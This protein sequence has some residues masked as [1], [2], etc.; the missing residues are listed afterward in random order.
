MAASL[1]GTVVEASELG[2]LS[3]VAPAASATMSTWNRLWLG[4]GPGGFGPAS[5]VR[6]SQSVAALSA[7]A[8]GVDDGADMAQKTQINV[9]AVWGGKHVVAHKLSGGSVEARESPRDKRS[10]VFL[11]TG[12]NTLLCPLRDGRRPV[13]AR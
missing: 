2:D 10:T 8:E 3:S 13:V 9:E 7:E 1:D 6:K 5:G 11:F 4:V 12:K